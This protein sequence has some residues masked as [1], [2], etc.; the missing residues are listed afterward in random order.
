MT[1][2]ELAGHIAENLKKWRCQAGYSSY[3]A[4]AEA[5]G[6]TPARYYGYES[7]RRSLKVTDA[8]AL[9]DF[10]CISLDDLVGRSFEPEGVPSITEEDM[11]LVERYHSLNRQ[12]KETVNAVLDVQESVG[13]ATSETGLMEA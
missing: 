12:G 2:D 5:V 11:L 4:F 1:D 7:G 3:K 6:M 9:A 10:L 8:C 13:E